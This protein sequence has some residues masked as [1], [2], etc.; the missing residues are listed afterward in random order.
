[1]KKKSHKLQPIYTEPYTVVKK[2]GNHTSV[3]KQHDC[4]SREA[5]NSSKVY[6]PADNPAGRGPTLVE[7]TRELKQKR[8]RGRSYLSEQSREEEAVWALPKLD[9]PAKDL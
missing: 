2:F 4:R 9:V 3:K 1:M 6:T 7:P 8:I 5:E